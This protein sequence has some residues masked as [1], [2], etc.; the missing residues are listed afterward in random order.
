MKA[1]ETVSILE[2]LSTNSLS[3]N[4]IEAQKKVIPE[5][6]AYKSEK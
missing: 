6:E 2:F 3:G 4:M 5:M 1:A